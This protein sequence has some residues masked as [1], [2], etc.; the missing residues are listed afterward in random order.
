MSAIDY[1]GKTLEDLLTE[2]QKLKRNRIYNAVWMG[3]VVG[4]MIY[5]LATRGFG[6][7][8]IA[9]PVVLVALTLKGIHTQNQNLASVQRE[10]EK[11][12]TNR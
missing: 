7:I 2:E 6:F 11:R 3:F 5:R 4:I 1:S 10:I 8:A 12:Q 9:I